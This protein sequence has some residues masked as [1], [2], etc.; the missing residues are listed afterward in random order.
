MRIQVRKIYEMESGWT[1]RDNIREGV[2]ALRRARRED[3]K[4]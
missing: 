4:H 2:G 3:A 1:P